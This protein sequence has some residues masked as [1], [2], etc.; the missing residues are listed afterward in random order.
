MA[1][2]G[3][4]AGAGV[5]QKI[6]NLM[7][8][9]RVY[10]EPFLGDA[11]VM[12]AKKPAEWNVGVDLDPDAPGLAWVAGLSG[13]GV[14]RSHIAIV[15]DGIQYLKE[16]P[17]TGDE[18]VYCDPPYL[19]ST[20]GGRR[21]Y[22]HEMTHGQHS[23]LLTALKRVQSYVMISG[24]LSP[25]YTEQLKGWESIHFEAMTRGGY[26]KTEYLWFNFPPP[27]VLHDYNHLGVGFR[28]RER[29]KRKKARWLARLTKMPVL[30]RRCLLEALLELDPPDPTR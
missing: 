12:R 18:L 26:T 14:G 19:M 30:E 22:R 4:K 28:E 9:H 11:A 7:P 13:N 29:I 5:S 20:R 10:I 2:P 15:G 3:G 16:R 24:Y 17:W 8:P 1:Y 27:T 6:I 21:L 23:M 25:L